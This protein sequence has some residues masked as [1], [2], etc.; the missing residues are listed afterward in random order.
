MLDSSQVFSLPTIVE[1]E[2]KRLLVLMLLLVLGVT[3][4]YA[5]IRYDFQSRRDGDWNKSGAGGSWNW[6]LGLGFTFATRVPT[7]KEKS[8]TLVDNHHI[9][10][11]ESSKET[12]K[13]DQFSITKNATLTIF[14]SRHLIIN[15]GDG[16]DF[17]NHGILNING[18]LSSDGNAPTI[19]NKGTGK[20]NVNGNYVFTGTLTNEGEVH[21]LNYSQLSGT[22][23]NKGTIISSR[24][25]IMKP[26]GTLT[27]EAG[28]T[29][30]F[31]SIVDIPES[32]SNFK[33]LKL[34]APGI[35]YLTG[36][37]KGLEYLN[38]GENTY[39]HKNGFQ[40]DADINNKCNLPTHI[41]DGPTITVAS[42]ESQTMT[43]YVSQSAKKHPIYKFTISR[44]AN[45][46]E[47]K[48]TG[49]SF[50]TTGSAD[51]DDI[52][53]FH[54]Y[55]ASH[56]N[57]SIAMPINPVNE[58]GILGGGAGTHSFNFS[59]QDVS[60]SKSSMQ[61]FWITADL[62]SEAGIGNDIGVSAIT[63]GNIHFAY[64]NGNGSKHV[65]THDGVLQE[66]SGIT[67]ELTSDNQISEQ[68]ISKGSAKNPVYRFELQSTGNNKLTG[69]TFYTDDTA[70]DSDKYIT[71]NDLSKFQLYGSIVD[72]L[73]LATKI[74]S[75]IESISDDHKH[76][77]SF[78]DVSYEFPG[79][80]KHYF[81]ITVDLT[82]GAAHDNHF[83]IKALTTGDITLKG[84]KSGTADAGKKQKIVAPGTTLAD[85]DPPISAGTISRGSQKNPIYSFTFTSAGSNTL[86]EVNFSTTETN[87]SSNVLK[88]QLYTSTT[89]YF[90]AAIKIG[91]D[92]EVSPTGGVAGLYNTFDLD[93]PISDG[94]PN[95]FWITADISQDATVDE[96]ITVEEFTSNNGIIHN[97]KM[98]VGDV[99]GST[100]PGATQI[101]G[102]PLLMVR[103]H[104]PAIPAG[105]INLDQ[106]RNPIYRFTITQDDSDETVYLE[107]IT[108][109][110]EGDYESKNFYKFRM[111]SSE[112][113]N[114]V[115][116]V[117]VGEVNPAAGIGEREQ[118]ITLKTPLEFGRNKTRYFWISAVTKFTPLD[119]L[120]PVPN[121]DGEEGT[122]M[123]LKV[124]AL[125]LEAGGIGIQD[126]KGRVEAS[127]HDGE[128]QTIGEAT[129]GLHDNTS[130]IEASRLAPGQ[131]KRALHSFYLESLGN[132]T[133]DKVSFNTGGTY[134]E[135]DITRFQLWAG[136]ENDLHSA[137]QIGDD[138][139]YNLGVG[140]HTFHDLAVPF[141][142]QQNHYFWI[143]VDT[144]NTPVSSNT[145]YVEAITES[146]IE[147]S[148]GKETVNGI[149]LQGS[150]QMFC[151]LCDWSFAKGQTITTSDVGSGYQVKVV[152]HRIDTN[153]GGENVYVGENCRKDFGDIRFFEDDLPLS[154]WMESNT[155]GEKATFWVKLNGDLSKE[156]IDLVMRYGHEGA[157]TTSD[158]TATFDFF[159]DFNQNGENSL[160]K[161]NMHK[162]LDDSTIF[163][164]RGTNHVRL[165]DCGTG[166]LTYGHVV[167][168]SNKTYDSFTNGAIE[169]RYNAC[170]DAIA[171]V[172]FRGVFGN[173]GLG[174]KGRSDA[175]TNGVNGGQSF[176]S[177]PYYD[178]DHLSDS[179]D[180]NSDPPTPGKWYHGKITAN[181][182][183]LEFYRDGILKAESEQ[184]VFHGPAKFLFKITLA[185]RWILTGYLCENLQI[186]N[187]SASD[188][189]A[190]L[191]H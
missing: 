100:S 15:H 79:G 68:G 66:I 22:I 1:L 59:N 85:M 125:A 176:L 98:A 76:T 4:G 130:N 160:D 181:G 134:I 147:P 13:V 121:P 47:V 21:L 126:N 42:E 178:W 153:E 179:E 31:N 29:I 132:I 154:Y 146:D 140:K 150:E 177:P 115:S 52:E 174:Y 133:L 54:L 114:C 129:V 33:N 99:V 112:I 180:P 27:H 38:L 103:S 73:T 65:F 188:G 190:Y 86:E 184:A 57:F 32:N 118:T 56:D 43:A 116:A 44:D 50:T 189:E 34:T 141:I 158:G 155:Y 64:S 90:G 139:A 75:D 92:I 185:I 128:Y 149:T 182:K 18:T 14:P 138:I 60:L 87:L 39:L 137:G 162:T 82:E 145:I 172:G 108:F 119:S 113:D 61:H 122:G 191:L 91:D 94:V 36:D 53:K 144:G 93:Y 96:T 127:T 110:T 49:L 111:G 83:T 171:E 17:T 40:L 117:A 35:Y 104:D 109:T 152:V 46:G 123:G 6:N 148:S 84:A 55:S 7:Y 41:I 23:I 88:Y 167:L 8:I 89:N 62:S 12:P 168:G 67:T 95:F 106:M 107:S 163:I 69:L 102:Y 135:S 11:E 72:N 161:W 166:D 183:N 45:P 186:Q 142:P 187:L 105:T 80:Q 74:G 151:H 143:T 51:V 71:N 173:P 136:I 170:V 28:S 16:V 77:F 131:N 48:L 30:I 169:F 70:P 26:G 20:I 120:D 159:D 25:D 165:G 101:I 63:E 97:I 3:T 175:R 9:K 164:P 2:P 24:A 81:W 157:T 58:D 5:Q 19:L 124:K 156:S 78:S 37:V 10:I